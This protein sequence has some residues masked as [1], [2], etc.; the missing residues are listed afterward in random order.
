ML[1]MVC[2]FHLLY[3]SVL[4]GLTGANQEPVE[5]LT[6]HDSSPMVLQGLSHT[7]IPVAISVGNEHLNEVSSTVIM[8]EN[9]I[10]THILA[11]YPATKINT[12]VVGHH[13]LCDKNQEQN[14]GLVLPSMKN[15][16]YTLTRW[17]LEREIK[18]S[19]SFSS[20]CLHS[21]SVLYVKPVLNFLEDINSTYLVN[22]PPN[23]SIQSDETMRLVFSHSES[24]KKLGVLNL[25]KINLIIN[26][27]EERKPMTRKLSFIDPFPTRPT[28][29][30]PVSTPIGYSVPS[31][32]AIS[33]LPPLV[34]TLSPLSPPPLSLPTAPGLPPPFIGPASPPF[35]FNLPPCNPTNPGFAAPPETGVMQ[36]L[37]CVAKPSVPAETLQEAM[38]YACG[39]GGADCEAIGS[40]GSCFYPDTVVAHASYAFNSYWQKS[41]KN[42]GTCSFGG[43]AMIINADPSFQHCRF[44]LS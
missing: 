34:G 18:V 30:A 13:V 37:W 8:A 27:P 14:M 36:G 12:I 2:L 7:G 16:Y 9:W 11:Y 25:N 38:D 3:F 41:K 6:L 31:N 17:G 4:M 19:A 22:P 26:S 10:R 44:I 29:L 21:S 33:P 40:L 20:N 23:L 43:T 24:M 35:G 15:I 5:I 32:V 1:K 28:P 39:E 42:G